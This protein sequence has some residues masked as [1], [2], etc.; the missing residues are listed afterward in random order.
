MRARREAVAERYDAAFAGLGALERPACPPDR[1]DARHLY[2]LRLVRE[3]LRID[4][5]AFMDELKRRGVGASVHFIPLHVH[6]YYRDTFGYR[7]ESLP[8]ALDLYQRS[9]SLPFFSSM[10]DDQVG[11]VI[12]AVKGLVREHA[13]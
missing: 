12:A 6:P 7:P 10:T 2:V 8:V 13:R 1:T 11:R 9:L 5:N 3:A 4:R